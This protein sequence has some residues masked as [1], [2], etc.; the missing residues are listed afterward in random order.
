MERFIIPM[1]VYSPNRTL[2]TKRA[3]RDL[4]VLDHKVDALTVEPGKLTIEI[5]LPYK[6]QQI[7]THIQLG[8]YYPFHPPNI[9]VEYKYNYYKY[10]LQKI[11]P[12]VDLIP[13]ILAYA[14][15][16]T[17]ISIKRFL[18][19]DNGQRPEIIQKCEKILNPWSPCFTLQILV[20]YLKDLLREIEL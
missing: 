4:N 18:Y 16:K 13:D 7:T 15:Y 8:R 20:N 14:E 2:S 19:E 6:K 9:F 10:Y 12:V 1:D 5:K 17:M 11:I 3:Q